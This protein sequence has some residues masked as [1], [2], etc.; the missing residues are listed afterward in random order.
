M[1]MNGLN[2]QASI[3]NLSQLN[4]HQQDSHNTP[5]VNQEQNAELA[6][7]EAARRTKQ[8]MQPDKLEGKIIKPEDKNKNNLA[9][10][11]RKRK[12]GNKNISRKKTK[13]SGNFIDFSV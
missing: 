11:K 1:Y 12:K 6:K 10:K 4:R 8:P 5:I 7:D 9:K 3:H 2:F 13:N